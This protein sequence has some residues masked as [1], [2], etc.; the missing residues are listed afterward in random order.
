MERFEKFGYA[1]F[2]LLILIITIPKISQNLIGSTVTVAGLS[3]N[4]FTLISILL[5]SVIGIFW[6]FFGTKPDFSTASKRFR[7][8]YNPKSDMQRLRQ[9]IK[10]QKEFGVPNNKIMHRLLRVGWD[11]EVLYS[12]FETADRS[13]VIKVRPSKIKKRRIRKRK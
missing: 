4:D 7:K 2:L 5:I 11:Q 10:E 3:A 9:Y 13:K 1:I 6:L 8:L 12:A